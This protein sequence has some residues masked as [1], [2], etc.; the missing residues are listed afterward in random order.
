MNQIKFER[1]RTPN[2]IGM[3]SLYMYFLGLSLRNASKAVVI[4]REEK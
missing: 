2:Y 3:Y 4:F 1:N